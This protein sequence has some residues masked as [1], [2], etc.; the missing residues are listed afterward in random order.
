M[1]IPQPVSWELWAGNTLQSSAVG[2]RINLPVEDREQR[3]LQLCR[4]NIDLH[5]FI[6]EPMCCYYSDSK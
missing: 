4:V 6:R 1:I 3:T 5:S 2:K